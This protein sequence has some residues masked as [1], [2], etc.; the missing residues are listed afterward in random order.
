MHTY[1]CSEHVHV[2]CAYFQ[3][4]SHRLVTNCKCTTPYYCSLEG[5]HALPCIWD[6]GSLAAVFSDD[7]AATEVPLVIQRVAS[8]CLPLPCAYII[9]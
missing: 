2:Q 9:L 8:W 3:T 1:A 6:S 4:V 7:L 5:A